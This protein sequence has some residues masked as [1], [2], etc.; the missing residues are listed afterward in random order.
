VLD[1]ASTFADKGII[2][3][4]KSRFVPVAIDQAYQRRQQDAEGDFYRKIAG[5]SPRNNFESTTQGLYTAGPDGKLF[6]FTNHRG[7]DRVREMLTQSL[8]QYKPSEAAA[9][10]R[11][12]PDERYN[13]VPPEG[14]L[15][16]RVQTKVI[17]GYEKTQAKW[18]EIFQQ[19]ISRDNLWITKKEHELLVRGE[20]P[21]SLQLRMARF[22]LVDNTRGEPPMWRSKELREV[23]FK[24]D[25]DSVSGKAKLSTESGDRTFD[26]HLSGT[27]DTDGE[28]VTSF[29]LVAQGDFKGE[30]RYTSGA[31]KGK[32]PLAILFTLADGS[33]IADKIPPQGSRGWVEGYL[34]VE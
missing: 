18:R 12:D 15:I 22:H 26:A 34:N 19:S 5:Q 2:E 29:D 7:A 33:D 13:P 21:R 25:Q 1:R 20:F 23:D 31:P 17:D 9:L 32:F 8:N 24:L 27:V 14:G 16:V 30:G 4:L 28:K 10:D 3:L 11:G 6:G